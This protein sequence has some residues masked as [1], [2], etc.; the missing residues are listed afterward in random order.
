M[1]FISFGLG[2]CRQCYLFLFGLAG[3]ANIGLD[4]ETVKTRA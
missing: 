2:D 4:A 3:L 1:L